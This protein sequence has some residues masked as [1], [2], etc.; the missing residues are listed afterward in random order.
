MAYYDRNLAYD[1]RLFE[2]EEIYSSTKTPEEKQAKK[3]KKEKLNTDVE[4][5]KNEEKTTHKRIKRRKN[6]F[7]NI[8]LAVVFAVAI[9]VVVGLIIHGQVQLTELNQQISAA[10]SDLEEQQSLY[11]QLEMKV[12]ASISTAVVEEYAENS[13]GMTKVS[14]S[15]KEFVSLSKG[16]KVELTEKKDDTVFDAIAD[17]ISSLWA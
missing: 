10:K 15:Q 16:D 5:Q 6:N 14:N 12:D 13:L 11:T 17:A 3:P 8:S 2:E 9:V 7:L 1:L 4:L